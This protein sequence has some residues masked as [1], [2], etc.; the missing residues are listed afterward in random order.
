MQA[1][2][3]MNSMGGKRHGQSVARAL[4]ASVKLNWEARRWCELCHS[5]LFLFKWPSLTME[6]IA[7]RVQ[8]I[9]CLLFSLS[10]GGVLPQSPGWNKTIS[11]IYCLRVWKGMKISFVR[12]QSSKMK[13][14][15]NH[16]MQWGQMFQQ[17]HWVLSASSPPEENW[18]TPSICNDDICSGLC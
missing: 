1:L 5:C 2:E 12:F 4:V 3:S 10:F 14:G 11:L 17:C 8:K 15:F 7:E 9:E 18:S 13:M 16:S 6:V